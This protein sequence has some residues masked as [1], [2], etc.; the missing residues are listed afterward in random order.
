MYATLSDYRQLAFREISM[1]PDGSCLF[2]TIDFLIHGR[3]S[4]DGSFNV[5]KRVV[6]HILAN[7]ELFKVW[8]HD[9]KGDNFTSPDHYR[10]E[11]MKSSTYGSSCELIAASEIFCCVFKVYR[12]CQLLYKFGPEGAPVYHLKFTGH[13]QK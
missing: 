2:H 10:R 13:S 9:V 8:T 3:K 11:M 12:D 6:D 5:R 7:W 4:S 1:P